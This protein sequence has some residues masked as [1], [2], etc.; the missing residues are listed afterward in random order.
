[1]SDHDDVIPPSPQHREEEAV[2]HVLR[3][4][5]AGRHLHDVL[6]DSYV[7]D[8]T[9]G[10]AHDHILDHPEVTRAVGDD[11]IAEMRRMIDEA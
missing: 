3:E 7:T 6:Q 1:M 2:Q 4:V 10:G 9:E 5:N 11:I 8:R